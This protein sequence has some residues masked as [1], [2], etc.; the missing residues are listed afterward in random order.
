MR[1]IEAAYRDALIEE[2]EAYV[3]A[4]RK[5]D[6]KQ[7]AAALK[8]RYDHDVAEPD[9]NAEQDKK[10]APAPERADAEKAP[11]NTAERAP[12]RA[13]AEAKPTAA[14]KTAAKRTSAKPVGDK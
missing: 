7:V 13:S 12:Q 10:P 9:G 11:E 5:A 6:A 2:Y 14:K 3:R 1:D 8:D 4:N